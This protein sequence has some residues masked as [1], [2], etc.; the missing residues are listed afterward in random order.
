[1]DINSFFNMTTGI[2]R[3]GGGFRAVYINF[4]TAASFT[5]QKQNFSVVLIDLLIFS[6]LGEIQML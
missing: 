4:C 1:M 6:I 3:T 5:W 2:S